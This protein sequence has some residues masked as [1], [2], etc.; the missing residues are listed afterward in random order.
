MSTDINLN[1]IVNA[2]RFLFDNSGNVY[3]CNIGWCEP[4][5]IHV[6]NF[7][8]ET[9]N[10]FCTGRGRRL[11]F[12]HLDTL[13]A[14]SI[15]SF[16]LETLKKFGTLYAILAVDRYRYFKY[17]ISNDNV[18]IFELSIANEWKCANSILVT[19]WDTICGKSRKFF[20]NEKWIHAFKLHRN[21]LEIEK[22]NKEEWRPA[23]LIL[24]PPVDNGI[25]LLTITESTEF[26]HNNSRV[27]GMM[28]SSKLPIHTGIWTIGDMGYTANLK[29]IRPL[30]SLLEP[31]HL[32]LTNPLLPISLQ[33]VLDDKID[34]SKNVIIWTFSPVF[35]EFRRE[36]GEIASIEKGDEHAVVGIIK[37]DPLVMNSHKTIDYG[38]TSHFMFY[39]DD[40]NSLMFECFL[41]IEK[42][43]INRNGL[44]TYNNIKQTVY[45]E[46]VRIEHTRKRN[47]SYAI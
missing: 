23:S 31:N 35:G 42:Y 32:I 43:L 2:D 7:N 19:E 11:I 20:C 16:D 47:K 8:K 29:V 5:G 37:K 17:T 4:T 38:K 25:D 14:D 18:H 24:T 10:Y 46:Y 41:K 21:F 12:D 33:D 34:C 40:P 39:E 36:V 1:A 45:D 26:F 30:I 28:E 44:F 6:S 15:V 27:I 22:N 3:G 13:A 9:L